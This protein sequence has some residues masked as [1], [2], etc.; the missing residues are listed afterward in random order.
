MITAIMQ[1]YFFPY[2]GYFQLIAAS[3]MFV[4]HDDVQYIKGGWINRNRILVNN[5]PAWIVLPVEA[6]IHSLA[7]NQRRYVLNPSSLRKILRQIEGAYRCA[8]GFERVYE[9][10]NRI[11]GFADSNV[12]AFN[13][14]LL[15][16]LSSEMGIGTR[17]ILSSEIQKDQNLRAQD[18]VLAICN[19][20]AAKRYINLPGGADLYEPEEF[21]RRG[22]ELQFLRS[23]ARPYQQ[24]GAPHVSTL[25]ILDVM[26]FNNAA[27]VSSFLKEFELRA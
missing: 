24:F 27:T 10:V 22:I 14:N 9:T 21:S 3:D 18:R 25:S 5:Q 6:A 7:I 8:P 26:M 12:A 15:R 19:A 11:L 2:I 17:M 16:V 23:R 20:T 1:P 13:A 4:I